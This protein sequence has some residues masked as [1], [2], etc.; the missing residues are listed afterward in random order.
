M[1][2]EKPKSNQAGMKRLLS[3]IISLVVLSSIVCSDQLP[4]FQSS[5][6]V[7]AALNGSAII[8][9][10][11]KE[12]GSDGQKLV[13]FSDTG[14]SNTAIQSVGETMWADTSG[15]SAVRV[16][17]E[18]LT[19]EEEKPSDASVGHKITLSEGAS[20]IPVIDDGTVADHA[21]LLDSNDSLAEAS[22]DDLYYTIEY[23]VV[24][25]GYYRQYYVSTADQ[26]E[27]LL[28][29]YNRGYTNDLRFE[30]SLKVQSG[31]QSGTSVG[32]LGIVLLCDLDLGGSSGRNWIGFRNINVYLEI[33]GNGHTI[34]NGKFNGDS[35]NNCFLG[36]VKGNTLDANGN[37][38]YD[39][40]GNVRT[41]SKPDRYI[42]IHDLT[43]SNMFIGHA[44]GMFSTSVYC[45][46]F[47]NVNWEN[48]LA[49][50]VDGAESSTAIVLGSSYRRTYF[51]DCTIRDS[52]V[53]GSGHCATFASYDGSTDCLT[54]TDGAVSAY[55]T[56][57][58]DT[59]SKNF[60]TTADTVTF[61]GYY[62]ASIP[63]IGEYSLATTG[64]ALSD[65]EAVEAQWK[66][67][68]V[69]CDG[70]T[71]NLCAG[72]YPVMYDNCAAI[73][74]TV[75]DVSSNHSGTFVSCMQS[76]I[77]FRNCFSNSTIYMNRLGGVFIGA[78]IGSGNGFFYPYDCDNDGVEESSFVNSVFTQCYTSGAVEGS[79]DIG[80]FVG[81][82]FDDPRA[83]ARGLSSGAATSY[84]GR[85][86][87]DNCYSVSSVGMSYSG[88]YVGGFCGIVIGNICGDTTLDP[89]AE[90][91]IFRNCYAAG[92]VGGISTLTG[93]DSS[94]TNTIGGFFGSYVNYSDDG[95]SNTAASS[96][97]MKEYSV[98]LANDGTVKNNTAKLINCYYDMQTTAMR[99]RD[100]GNGST[101][102]YSSS[103][104]L[105]HTLY[106]DAGLT[107]VYTQES[108][109]KNVNGLTDSVGMGNDSTWVNLKNYYPLLKS[110]YE[111]D[112][113]YS[114]SY[115]TTYADAINNMQYERQQIYYY[116]ALASAATVFL[117]H[118]DEVLSDGTNPDADGNFISAGK[119]D[120]TND[121]TVY[122]T[123]R[124][125]T[126]KFEFTSTTPSGSIEWDTAD[127]KNK[128]SGFY[129]YLGNENGF[130][131]TWADVTSSHGDITETY[132]PS[133]LTI[134]NLDGI[135]KCLDFAPGKQWVD[136]A[137]GDGVYRG[138][139]DFRLLPTAYLNAGGIITVNVGTGNH[140]HY[141]CFNATEAALTEEELK[142]ALT[143][144][145]VIEG[146]YKDYWTEMDAPA[147]EARET[148]FVYT[149]SDGTEYPYYTYIENGNTYYYYEDKTKNEVIVS[150]PNTDGTGYHTERLSR[151]T[152]Y[153]GVAYATTDRKRMDP[154][155]TYNKQSGN[156][157]IYENQELVDWTGRSTNSY[158]SNATA[159]AVYSGYL[160]NASFSGVGMKSDETMLDQKYLIKYNNENSALYN[161]ST[162]GST[163][164][165]V[166]KA[167]R[168][169]TEL[170]Y[171][172]SDE[173]TD[174]A[175]LQKF[176][177][178]ADF[179]T[180]DVG[181]YYMVYQ[182][183]LNDGRYLEDVRLIQV[184]SDE[185]NVSMVTG[186]LN[187]EHTVTDLQND[188]GK[189]S[190][191]TAIDQYVTDDVT[192]QDG[193]STWRRA[194]RSSE[195]GFSEKTAASYY[196]T[197]SEFAY[198]TER[199]Y[200]NETYHVK[201]W[202]KTTGAS[203]VVAGWRRSSEYQLVT[204]I[205]EAKSATGD[206]RELAAVNGDSLVG[207]TE[208]SYVYTSYQASQDIETKLYK[209]TETPG[210]TKTFTISALAE[211]NVSD[212]EESIVLNFSSDEGGG[213][214][215][216]QTESF[217]VTALFTKIE[218]EVIGEKT[219]LLNP[220]GVG[221]LSDA[222]QKETNDSDDYPVEI[223][224]S[225]QDQAYAV[226]NTNVDALTERKAVVAGDTLT[227][228]VKL[229]N[230]GYLDTKTVE[231]TDEVP[232]GC[233]FVPDS[234]KIYAQ[235]KEKAS[236]SAASGYGY[237]TEINTSEDGLQTN[238]YIAAY[239]AA[240]QLIWNIPSIDYNT[241]YY[242]EYQ[243]TVNDIGAVNDSKLLVNTA[244]WNYT[245]QMQS[246]SRSIG[247][248]DITDSANESKDD[249]ENL[250]ANMVISHSD[251]VLDASNTAAQRT[252]T[253][254]FTILEPVSETIT[255][256]YANLNLSYELPESFTLSGDA[257]LTKDGT[258]VPYTKSDTGALVI[259]GTTSELSGDY[260]LTFTG[261][262]DL[263]GSNY[264]DTQIMEISMK[265]GAYYNIY[266]NS[267]TQTLSV[268]YFSSTK[269]AELI[270]NQVETDVT[271]LYL[272]IEKDRKD[273]AGQALTD[274]DALQ[275]F[276]F[277]IE[278]F[279]D[280]AAVEA[281][282]PTETFYTNITCSG[283]SGSQIV[284]VDHRGYYR[285]TEIDGWSDTD[286]NFY[287]SKYVSNINLKSSQSAYYPLRNQLMQAVGRKNDTS[288]WITLPELT[289]ESG[290]FPTSIGT[291]TEYED[292]P[293]A[294]FINCT[295]IFAYISSQGNAKNLLKNG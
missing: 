10:L 15:N 146:L 102:Y 54:L 159:F 172:A 209:I 224:L 60:Q 79:Q 108:T 120:A 70:E 5:E 75:Y 286:Y 205:I 42:N 272:R 186:I 187:K 256:T 153:V 143:D 281:E 125:I 27:I 254:L 23:D 49:A 3:V 177:G 14:T 136:V 181:Y 8:S 271:H 278:Y 211:S 90:Q 234:M 263:L 31:E 92:E 193:V 257:V 132:H 208:Y 250:I 293:T 18:T 253:V 2:A 258:I 36:G 245:A 207:K 179:E 282:K 26:L 43:F 39:S 171:D 227:Y 82:V 20:E 56:Y 174:T 199:I 274:D 173:I 64:T 100:I 244:Q 63:E 276:L 55:S 128:T 215:S 163:I 38:S 249:T 57:I 61:N 123:V 238:G 80:G 104:P 113:S 248:T 35:S 37:L 202:T 273:A 240:G 277:M 30:N 135:Y 7:S 279:E 178:A 247:S 210:A 98:P 58:G 139:R 151:F 169:G 265:A 19:V 69:V 117:N 206:W 94:N 230:T 237:V 17:T 176:A 288:V 200:N 180:K 40:S 220:T 83:Y 111:P 233:T 223:S 214:L 91:H 74:C 116:Y 294:L 112:A 255:G 195:K 264:N 194:Y 166:Y 129:D 283:F 175:T 105:N 242:V 251:A 78:C 133:V 131:L 287:D 52:Y 12:L 259:A 267:A 290:A 34:Y 162:N 130:S 152:H 1:F 118:Y 191:Y 59:S 239:K 155:T 213:D 84:R 144:G 99:E 109:L 221:I 226:D 4:F 11:K 183:R 285:I 190:A 185:Y 219:V 28:Y 229:Q 33:N 29:Y 76:G 67:R 165:R 262:Q 232:D 148:A 161:N 204:L 241:D 72:F 32:K 216:T 140:Y 48:C 87:F 134:Y 289:Y 85:V 275:A 97:A 222:N 71:Y 189:N 212:I 88:S 9:I 50:S 280:D 168:N 95:K 160:Q 268:A 260:T 270:T 66:G 184:S 266:E 142:K 81:A 156:P 292:F 21:F 121:K 284:Q 65:I 24:L 51:K 218:A 119:I 198:N 86:V 16:A 25:D 6:P 93:T 47:N 89:E 157:S 182:W 46:Y 138:V 124:D 295:D 114:Y 62:Y 228:R 101:S 235:K 246:V 188:D 73:D 197:D 68:W 44:Q 269:W 127:E 137:I 41:E 203:T 231:V 170:T 103:V 236:T 192:M 150:I 149:A 243:V 164:V 122:D 110:F 196:D 225:D 154:D 45:A 106:Y 167:V 96:A 115:G 147:S 291:L 53:I 22:T 158:E 13:G 252:Y 217:R 261:M 201:S 126:R 77:V 145:Y 107:G 141:Y